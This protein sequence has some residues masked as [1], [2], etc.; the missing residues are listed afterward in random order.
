[1]DV[2]IKFSQLKYLPE[3][4]ECKEFT[5]FEYQ[6]GSWDKL[7]T[8]IAKAE[9][10]YGPRDEIDVNTR[11]VVTNL[12]H[13]T[14]RDGYE[15][16]CQRGDA[17]NRIKEYGIDVFGGRMSCHRFLANQLRALMHAG[18][19]IILAAMQDAAKATTW[20]SAQMGT[21]RLR[22]LKIGARV[23]ETVRRV[24]VHMSS[25]YPDRQNFAKIYQQLT[26]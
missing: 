1:M 19:D 11:F 20:A 3:M 7:R 2:C 8:V 4:F 13:A 26:C 21:L 17:E 12:A 6:A 5:D 24:W 15:H 25:S 23:I 10:T 22:L 14:P 18:A 9:I 16:Y